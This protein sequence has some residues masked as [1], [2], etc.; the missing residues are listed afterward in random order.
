[1]KW[2]LVLLL[3]V[4]I[5]CS[6]EIATPPTA[7]AQTDGCTL[8]AWVMQQQPHSTQT[9]E[10]PTTDLRDTVIVVN[11]VSHKISIPPGF[12]MSVFARVDTTRGLACSRDGVIYATSY[13]GAVYAMPDHNHLGRPDSIINVAGNLGDAHGIGFYHGEL[14]VSNNAGLYHLITNGESRVAKNRVLVS[15]LPPSG[16]HH[17]RN[18]VFD[19]LKSKIYVQVGSNGNIDTSDLTHRAQIVEMNIDGSDYRTFARGIRNAV[20][21]DLDPRT[22]ALWANNNGMDD[23]FGSGTQLTANNPSESVYLVCDGA[24]YGWPW[25]YG[26]Q[27]RNPLMPHLDT[28]IIR[29]FNGPVVEVLAHE[30]PLGLHFYRGNTFPVLYHNA[31]FQAYHGSW[32]RTPPA[33][34]RITVMWADSDGRNPRVTDFVNG[35]QPDSSGNRWGRPVSI[36]EGADSALYVSDDQAGVIY[37]IVWTGP[38]QT[39]SVAS[40]ATAAISIGNLIPN[41][42]RNEFQFD[43]TL[44]DRKMVRAELFDLLGNVVQLI[45]NK[46]ID[47]GVHTLQTSLAKLPEGAYILRVRIGSE[48]ISKQ[49][50]V[51]R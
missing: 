46:E 45:A 22:D 40:T 34:P 8:S 36:V 24:N 33:P 51:E 37:R 21:L 9:P 11:G 13:S 29:T 16:G 27:M 14:Y 28:S 43:L 30:A 19:T 12:T 3:L 39:N 26:F 17:S 49:I 48:T 10:L 25:A 18:F 47:A 44:G 42:A 35:F 23:I 6:R 32:D 2:P 4:A 5:G 15:P 50:I 20:G 7:K 1:M 41:P 38:K 31:I